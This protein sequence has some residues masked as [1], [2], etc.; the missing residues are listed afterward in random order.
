MTKWHQIECIFAQSTN[1]IWRGSSLTTQPIV[2][3]FLYNVH[4]CFCVLLTIR[5]EEEE[6][7][8]PAETK[9]FDRISWSFTNSLHGPYI[10]I[11]IWLVSIYSNAIINSKLCSFRYRI[12]VLIETFR[13]RAQHGYIYTSK[14]VYSIPH[15]IIWRHQTNQYNHNK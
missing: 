8:K 4:V 14:I 7:N 10:N 15:K 1:F 13:N 11:N 9:C 5:K 6:K 12:I 2:H 3:T